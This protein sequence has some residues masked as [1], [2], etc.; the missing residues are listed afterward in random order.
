MD[1]IVPLISERIR[2]QLSTQL[3]MIVA[4][5]SPIRANTVKIGRFQDNPVANTVFLAVNGG[6]PEDPNMKDGIVSLDDFEN[7]GYTV[8]PRE[9]GGGA[10]WWRRGT[11]KIGCYFKN[12]EE[13][14]ARQ[15]AYEVLGKVTNF[16]EDLSVSDL[17]DDFDEQ[18]NKLFVYGSTYAQSGGKSMF[19]WRGKVDWVCLTERRN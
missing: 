17:E 10:F 16:T 1:H 19:I 15:Y 11:V 9:I 8:P 7:I 18:A 4:E 2:D 6:D 5:D 13:N 14:L 12:V 3:Q